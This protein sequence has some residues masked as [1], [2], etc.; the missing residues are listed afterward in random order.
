MRRTALA[1]LLFVPLALS[2]CSSGPPVPTTFAKLDYSYLPPITLKVASVQIRNDYVPGPDARKFLAQAPEPPA[3]VLER[4]AHERLVADGS[5]G[6]AAFV[7]R[8][9]SL[10]QVGDTLVGKM[11]V[12]LNV[13]TSSGQRVGYAEA[14]VSRSET[15]PSNETPDRMRAALY[16]LTKEMMSSMNVELQYQIQKSLPDWLAYAPGGAGGSAAAPPTYN[17][18]N[19]IQAQPLP[20]PGGAPATGG[21]GQPTHLPGAGNP[22]PAASD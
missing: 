19:G 16:N 8:Q 6:S 15:A 1:G 7:I 21:Q 11:T 3:Q 14:S 4:M 22:A 2:A 12:D 5:P 9:A 20:G 10:H 18:N 13:R 17:A